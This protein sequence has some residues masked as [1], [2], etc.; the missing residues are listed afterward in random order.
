MRDWVDYIKSIDE[1]KCENCHL[2]S[3]GFH[4]ADWLALDNP[5]KTSCFG[6]TDNTY[7]ATAFYY[8]SVKLTAKAALVLGLEAE[9]K[10]YKELAGKIKK[11]FRKQ[12]FTES[13]NL[14]LHTQTALVLALYFRLAPEL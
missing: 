11:A 1:T 10:E 12:Y 14:T 9:A 6:G 7:V 4:F 8:Y 5:D 13:G 2:W 3:T